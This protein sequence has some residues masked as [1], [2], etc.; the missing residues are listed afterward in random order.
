[1]TAASADR[2]TAWPYLT[3]VP[4]V[5]RL[6]TYHLMLL[7]HNIM[8]KQLPETDSFT[9]MCVVFGAFINMCS[10]LFL[11]LLQFFSYY[12][13]INV[14][15]TYPVSLQ[16]VVAPTQRCSLHVAEFY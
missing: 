16:S 4:I 15:V 3:S 6:T 13:Y 14:H 11:S 10:H 12:G 2:I 9:L 5:V 1:M 7:E 8:E